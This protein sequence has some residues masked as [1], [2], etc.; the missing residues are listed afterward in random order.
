MTTNEEATSLNEE[1]TSLRL[2]D[3]ILIELRVI[4][5]L[6]EEMASE[7]QAARNDVGAILD[8][9]DAA[10]DRVHDSMRSVDD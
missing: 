1:A 2:L 3:E 10:V 6:I 7:Q 8:H 4:S 5:G 9:W